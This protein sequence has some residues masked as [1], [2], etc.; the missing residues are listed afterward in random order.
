[1]LTLA[2]LCAVLI[3]LVVAWA[4]DRSHKRHF[5]GRRGG[6]IATLAVPI[7]LFGVAELSG[8]NAFIAAFVGG[9]VFGGASTTLAPDHETA[10]LLETASD[11]LGFVVWFFFGGMLLKVFAVEFNWR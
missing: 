2:L 1:M 3:P 8:A 4:M 6:Q 11:L 10:G 5:S 9:L 7:L